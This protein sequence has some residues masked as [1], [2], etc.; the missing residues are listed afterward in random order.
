MSKPLEVADAIAYAARQ[1]PSMIH[2]IDVF[3]RD[4]FVGL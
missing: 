4:T 3:N 1:S 2:E